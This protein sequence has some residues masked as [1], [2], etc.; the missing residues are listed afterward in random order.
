MRNNLPPVNIIEAQLG[1]ENGGPI[2][3]FFTAECAREMDR[4]VPF[5]TGALARTVI[6]NGQPTENV[7]TDYIEYAQDYASYP[8]YGITHG[9]K[10]VYRTDMHPDATSYWDMHMW[11]AKQDDIIKAVQ[12]ELDKRGDIV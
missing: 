6:L 11:T 10:M 9:K 5:R 8:Y 12:K 7:H 4:F 1:L 2:H 3:A